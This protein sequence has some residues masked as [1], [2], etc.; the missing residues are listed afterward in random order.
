MQV[1]LNMCSI[2]CPLSSSGP[3]P[4]SWN[5]EGP[6]QHHCCSQDCAP[7][8]R[9]L[10]CCFWDLLE[11]CV[12]LGVTALIT[13]GSTVAFTSSQALLSACGTFFKLL[14]ILC[15][16]HLVQRH[17]LQL[18]S[19]VYPQILCPVGQP[20]SVCLYLEVSQNLS[21]VILDNPKEHV[22]V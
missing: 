16:F 8:D 5:L 10:G 9:D 2:S 14:M 13:N 12:Q 11:T 22:P 15:C 19:S 17:Q 21:S 18:P 20:T 6:A 7:L 3:L 1:R 4:K